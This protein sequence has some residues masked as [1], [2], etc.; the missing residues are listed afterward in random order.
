MIGE[1]YKIPKMNPGRGSPKRSIDSGLPVH[2][3]DGR[4]FCVLPTIA[5]RRPFAR[6]QSKFANL[7]LLTF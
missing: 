5:P 3:L 6:I 2:A 7:T 1:F 4:L